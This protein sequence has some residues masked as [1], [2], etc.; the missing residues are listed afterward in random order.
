VSDFL[1]RG[2]AFPA[3][4]G[5]RGGIALVSDHED[6]VQAIDIILRTPIGQR[7]MRPT[8]GSRLHELV[9]AQVSDDTCGLAELYVTEALGFWEPRIE[10]LE[11][12]AEPDHD[13]RPRLNIAIRYRVKATHDERSLVHPFY[14]IP[15]E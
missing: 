6:I 9:F 1:G 11:V 8:F 15:G 14:Q 3:K 5:G 7:V 13:N 2:W 4:P 12:V 10:V